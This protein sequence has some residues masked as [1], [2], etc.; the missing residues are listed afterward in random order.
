MIKR[1]Y[2]VWIDERLEDSITNLPEGFFEESSNHIAQLRMGYN[3]LEKS[4]IKYRLVT[5]ELELLNFILRDLVRIRQRK[6]LNISPDDREEKIL[7]LSEGEKP[8][9]KL[10]EAIEE[11]NSLLDRVIH[12]ELKAEMAKSKK[13]ET[14]IVRILKE[15]PAF[16]AVDGVEIGPYKV[17]DVVSMP[18]PNAHILI[19]QKYAKAIQF[20]KHLDNVGD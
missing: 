9:Q 11:Q 17:G 4:S 13:P 14:M 6:I 3:L 8:I 7:H 19:R 10:I 20:Q 16:V 5:K 18:T 15:I 1:V 12:G 2:K